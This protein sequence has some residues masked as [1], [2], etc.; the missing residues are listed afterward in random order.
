MTSDDLRHGL[1]FISNLMT[2]Q[3]SLLGIGIVFKLLIM[4]HA[5]LWASLAL[6]LL[7]VQA[8][9]KRSQVM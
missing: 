5:H 3:R 8:V 4:I 2:L 6:P 9:P 7:Y 1:N